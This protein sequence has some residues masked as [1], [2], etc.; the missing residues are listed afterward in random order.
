MKNTNYVGT[1]D[2]ALSS[3]AILKNSAYR[4][5]VACR[6]NYYTDNVARRKKMKRRIF[7]ELRKKFAVSKTSER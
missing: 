2:S 5:V 4:L 3:C 1:S 7:Y 6:G